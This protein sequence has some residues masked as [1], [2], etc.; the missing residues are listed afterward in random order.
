MILSKPRI[1]SVASISIKAFATLI[2]ALVP[3]HAFA[4]DCLGGCRY[5]FVGEPLWVVLADLLS[6]TV[7]CFVIA[8]Y[9]TEWKTRALAGMGIFAI[10]IV[11]V[12]FLTTP[13]VIVRYPLED[14][15]S[16][17]IKSN[18]TYNAICGY[19]STCPAILVTD[20]DATNPALKEVLNA[21]HPIGPTIGLLEMQSLQKV[22]RSIAAKEPPYIGDASKAI[23][24]LE[25][26]PDP[27]YILHYKQKYIWVVFT[28][29]LNYFDGIMPFT[30]YT[31]EMIFWNSVIALF[32]FVLNIKLRSSNPLGGNGREEHAIQKIKRGFSLVLCGFM[33]KRNLTKTAILASSAFVLSILLIFIFTSELQVR[34]DLVA[35]FVDSWAVLAAY[36]LAIPVM[37]RICGKTAVVTPD[38]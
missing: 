13:V 2:V 3:I 35:L 8:L 23:S 24:K 33:A 30:Y 6:V 27:S 9:I 1:T 38:Y 29:Q 4:Q 16:P 18:D 22:I 21:S 11:L 32:F 15:Y 7:A 31:S 17:G 28:F 20:S 10:S 36:T 12:L 14:V 34:A 5:S 25:Y 19:N 37:R 26:Y